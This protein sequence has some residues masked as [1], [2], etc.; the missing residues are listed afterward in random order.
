MPRL[1]SLKPTAVIALVAATAKIVLYVKTGAQQRI[2]LTE[3]WAEF[4]GVTP[5]AV[6]VLA[7]ILRLTSDATGDTALTPNPDDSDDGTSGV[8]AASHTPTG[9]A[10]AGVILRSHLIHPTSGK[11][12]IFPLGNEII[13]PKA[14]RIGLR[15]TAPADVNVWPG[16]VWR[17]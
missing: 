6:P 7:E 10:A 13:V 8:A 3:W 4:D 16:L 9:G 5:S 17:E 1:Y 2:D 11:H 12:V 15:L 14:G